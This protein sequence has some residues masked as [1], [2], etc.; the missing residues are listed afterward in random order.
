MAELTELQ[1]RTFAVIDKHIRHSHYYRTV[2]LATLYSQLVT[3]ENAESLLQRFNPSEDEELFQQ[4]VLLTQLVTPSICH[5][6]SRPL[7]EM[8]RV[9]PLHKG[10]Y[11]Q[12][13]ETQDEL[14]DMLDEYYGSYGVDGFLCDNFL[15]NNVSDPNSFTIT[16][17]DENGAYSFVKQ[18]E[19]VLDFEYKNNILQYLITKDYIEYEEDGYPVPGT[20]YNVYENGKLTT[21][22]QVAWEPK[23]D[24]CNGTGR[25]KRWY[26]LQGHKTDECDIC[27]GVGKIMTEIGIILHDNIL[28]TEDFR[29]FEIKTFSLK[30]PLIP[31]F[32]NGTIKDDATKG[33]TCVSIIHS[34]LPYLMKSVKTVSELDINVSLHA[35]LQKVVY[36]PACDEKDCIHGKLRDGKECKT[37]KGT[38]RLKADSSQVAITLTLPDD[39]QD[40]INLAGLTHYVELPIEVPK[41]LDELAEKY[42]RKSVKAVYSS[43]MFEKDTVVET[44]T[45]KVMDNQAKNN[46]LFPFAGTY[47]FAFKYLSKNILDIASFT[48]F[49][50]KHKF[51]KNL[52]LQSRE[53]LVNELK[54]VREANLSGYVLE[55]LENN[56]AEVLFAD[57]KEELRRVQVKKKFNPFKGKNDS[58]IAFLIAGELVDQKTITL[59]AYF[60]RIFQELEEETEDVWFYKLSYQDI[61]KAL[62]K[63][64]EEIINEQEK[65]SRKEGEGDSDPE[66]GDS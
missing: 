58:Q 26:L 43:E 5:T 3:G 17:H 64:V 54:I 41:L 56:Y 65:T 9:T 10:A 52:V 40:V 33:V 57:Q 48:D 50:I 12:S 13:Q 31:C 46:T 35:F 7:Y 8:A 15:T 22:T 34:A 25:L 21:Y 51:P 11:H 28:K 38:G 39:P 19:D 37:C 45:K 23:C 53:D 66:G 36:E 55:E 42:E 47:S 20:R 30:T 18:S 60:D 6:I 2:R 16:H 4:R 63:K 62:D 49:I 61:R 59:Y 44:A 1:K 14:M 32:R 29:M 24:K 27:S